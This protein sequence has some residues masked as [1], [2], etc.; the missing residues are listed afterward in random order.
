MALEHICKSPAKFFAKKTVDERI[1]RHGA[2][3]QHRSDVDKQDVAICGWELNKTRNE[4]D[5]LKRE[6][7]DQERYNHC[8]KHVGCLSP[9]LLSV[10]LV[11]AV[12]AASFIAG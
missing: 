6:H 2:D 3:S 4:N 1:A 8:Q 12:R 11:D 5:N 10:Y 7:A 9:L